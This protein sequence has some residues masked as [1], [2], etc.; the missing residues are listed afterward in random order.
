MM[1]FYDGNELSSCLQVSLGG[2]FGQPLGSS[3]GITIENVLG[4]PGCSLVLL[5]QGNCFSV[6]HVYQNWLI[7]FRM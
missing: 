7:L 3:W 4:S 6:I 1:D 2:G 5:F